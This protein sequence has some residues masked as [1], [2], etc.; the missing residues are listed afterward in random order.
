MNRQSLPARARGSVNNN[1]RGFTLVEI[2]IVVVIIGILA[3]I[4]IPQYNNYI[5]GAKQAAADNSLEQFSILLESYR[6]ENGQYPGN[7][8]YVYTEDGSGAVTDTITAQLPDFSPRSPSAEETTSH[9]SVNITNSGAAGEQAIVIITGVEGHTG[10]DA[11]F[12][13]Q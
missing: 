10:F 7:G 8:V 6:A 2:L 12:T 4:A 5:K 11:S 13:F 9:F 1:H 3:A